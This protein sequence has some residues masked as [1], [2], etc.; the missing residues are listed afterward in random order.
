VAYTGTHDN[1]T[2]VGW[3]RS[4]GVDRDERRRAL[5]YVG[6]SPL[7]KRKARWDFIR[8]LML[9]AADWVILPMQDVLGLGSGARM[10]DP[11]SSSGNW[12]WRLAPGSLHGRHARTLADMAA[13]YGRSSR[14][15]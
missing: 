13:L 3:L 11:A 12:Q 1:Q 6:G 2:L 5:R 15:R 9:S 10:N 8:A 7:L 14:I 4:G